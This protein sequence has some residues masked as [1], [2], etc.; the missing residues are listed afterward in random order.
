MLDYREFH[1]KAQE[2]KNQAEQEMRKGAYW[3][4]VEL[5]QEAAN[6]ERQA[7][8]TARDYNKVGCLNALAQALLLGEEYQEA[9]QAAKNG[10]RLLNRL[11]S[12]SNDDPTLQ[13]EVVKLEDWLKSELM[14]THKNVTNGIMENE[15]AMGEVY[16]SMQKWEWGASA[17]FIAPFRFLPMLKIPQK[18]IDYIRE[19]IP[20]AGERQLSLNIGKDLRV[21]CI[22]PFYGDLSYYKHHQVSRYPQAMLF[23]PRE[24]L[25][26]KGLVEVHLVTSPSFRLPK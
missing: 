23:V 9:L 17:D 5:Y 10:E 15:R 11:S 14:R 18:M 21:D 19:S 1:A 16:N 6:I 26:A 2:I 8:D 22:R 7:V 20:T 24:E 4:A 3:R 12:M 25:A 13:Y